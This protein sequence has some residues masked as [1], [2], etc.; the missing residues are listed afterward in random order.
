MSLP[1]WLGDG[2]SMGLFLDQRRNRDV[3]REL[4]AGKSVLNLFCYTGSF[5]VAAA[6][7]GARQVTNVDLSGR[8]LDRARLSMAQNAPAQDVRFVKADVFKYLGQAKRRGERFDLIVLD[9]P[10]FGTRGRRSTF[11]VDKDYGKLAQQSLELLRPGGSLLAVTNHRKTSV[12]RLRRVLHA[13]VAA[14]GHTLAQM[15]DA[16]GGADFPDGPDGPEPSKSVWIR[17]D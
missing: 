6:L 13:A 17:V 10:S 1:V 12:G 9:P 7:G 16:R 3:L 15:K 14:S 2:M 4:A 5:A 8:A 11:S